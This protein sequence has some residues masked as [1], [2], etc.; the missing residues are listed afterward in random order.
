MNTQQ[1]RGHTHPPQPDRAFICLDMACTLCRSEHRITNKDGF[2]TK[3]ALKSLRLLE[4]A[5]TEKE[6]TTNTAERP[7]LV[8]GCDNLT[9]GATEKPCNRRTTRLRQL[10][11]ISLTLRTE[12]HIRNNDREKT[13]WCQR[14]GKKMSPRVKRHRGSETSERTI[15]IPKHL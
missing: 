6:T 5:Q 14:R 8:H 9:N 12:A 10:H 1:G 11:T 13:L 3:V 2:E 4:P 7:M 15:R